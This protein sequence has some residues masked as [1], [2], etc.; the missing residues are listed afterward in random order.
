MD[1]LSLA[2]VHDR[3]IMV[4]SCGLSYE[5]L[6]SAAVWPGGWLRPPRLQS[7]LR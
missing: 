7:Q 5:G 4:L 3:V 2:L 1:W 6:G